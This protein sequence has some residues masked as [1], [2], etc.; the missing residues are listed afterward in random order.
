MALS[1]IATIVSN[2]SFG[3]NEPTWGPYA[4]LFPTDLLGTYSVTSNTIDYADG[5]GATIFRN[6]I[7]QISAQCTT[8]GANIAANMFDSSTT[9]RWFCGLNGGNNIKLDGVSTILYDRACYD[10][11]TGNYIG[12]RADGTATWNTNGYQGEYFQIQYPFNFVVTKIYL[13]TRSGNEFARAP[14]ILYI[15]GSSTGSS[16][17]LVDTITTSVVNDNEYSYTV[18]NS[19]KYK[20][21]R[22]LANRVI[23]GNNTGDNFSLVSFKTEGTAWSL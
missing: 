10:W 18:S 9:T 3:P 22:F 23:G 15:F 1:S 11:T 17:T 7:Y 2:Q 19:T 13:K 5:V 20:Y 8:P 21:Y 4:F 12:G 16:W 6:G 14:K